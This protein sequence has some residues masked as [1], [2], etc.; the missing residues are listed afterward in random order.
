M[1]KKSGINQLW[2][3]Y[4]QKGQKEK[5]AFTGHPL[6]RIITKCCAR[7]FPK[8]KVTNM[9]EVL[10]GF[11]KQAPHKPGGPK[12]K[13]PVRKGQTTSQEELESEQINLFKITLILLILVLPILSRFKR[14]VISLS[15]QEPY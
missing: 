3:K 6:C 14:Y 12:Y 10:I 5:E 8:S 9:E 7:V 15:T 2:A 1:M 4:R 11:L 13:K